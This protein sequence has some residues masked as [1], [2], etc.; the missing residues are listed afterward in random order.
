MNSLSK[1]AINQ[2]AGQTIHIIQDTLQNQIYDNPCKRMAVGLFQ[3]MSTN[4]EELMSQYLD[5]S[6]NI[7]YQVL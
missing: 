5:Q 6:I 4:L 7:L 2:I 1:E 3:D